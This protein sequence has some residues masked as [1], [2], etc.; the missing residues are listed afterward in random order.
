M[1]PYENIWCMHQELQLTSMLCRFNEVLHALFQVKTTKPGLDHEGERN[2]KGKKDL[3]FS[4]FLDPALVLAKENTFKND[5]KTAL[6]E[7]YHRRSLHSCQRNPRTFKPRL[8]G[9]PLKTTECQNSAT[10]QSALGLQPLCWFL[11][12]EVLFLQVWPGNRSGSI[13][14]T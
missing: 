3:F 10:L 6:C 11:L 12:P 4:Q 8:L 2:I 13:R 5:I 7:Y 14:V 1:R 9:H